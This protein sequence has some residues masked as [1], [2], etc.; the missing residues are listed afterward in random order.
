MELIDTHTHPFDEAFDGDREQ[1]IERARRAGVSKMMCPAIDSSTHAR[2]FALC[3]SYP[4]LC[5]PMMG[6]HPTSINDN[7]AWRD[8]LATVESY[9]NGETGRRFYAVGEVGLD[10]HW[11]RE[12]FR[13][14]EEAFVRQAEAALGLGLPLV[15]HTRDAWKEMIAVLQRFRGMGLRGIMHAFSGTREDYRAVKECG[16]FLFGIG[17]VVTYRNSSVADVV[18]EMPLE[19]VVLETDSPYLTPV[20]FRGK[21]NETAYIEYVCS[22][23]A[24]LKGLSPGEIA[25][26]TTHN[27]RQMF[28]I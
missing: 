3:D 20:P 18:K 17:G 28:R 2:L 21:R 19:D 7:P 4:D 1:M 27:A 5:L 16:D 26:V 8:E 12:W 22:R 6:L 11:S 15:V 10:L 24:A 13:E 25:R 23:V 14:Q 9:L